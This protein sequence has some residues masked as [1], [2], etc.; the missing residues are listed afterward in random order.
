M[1]DDC[2]DCGEFDELLKDDDFQENMAGPLSEAT[3]GVDFVVTLKVHAGV[4]AHVIEVMLHQYQSLLNVPATGEAKQDM[5]DDLIDI[6]SGLQNFKENFEADILDIPT[7]APHFTE[8]ALSAT[9]AG[10]ITEVTITD[11]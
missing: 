3:K 10:I 8:T 2:N 4:D 9:M 6:A 7:D 1:T 11:G 5:L